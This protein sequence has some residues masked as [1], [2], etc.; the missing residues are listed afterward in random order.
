MKSK[1][2]N[3]LVIFFFVFLLFSCSL[4]NQS[5]IV[6]ID[7]NYVNNDY[8]IFTYAYDFQIYGLDNNKCCLKASTVSSL[9]SVIDNK[10][11]AIFFISSPSCISCKTIISLLN[12][13]CFDK[14]LTIYDIDL[15]SSIYPVFET[16]DFDI[17]INVLKNGV[18]NNENEFVIPIII[19][20]ND[21]IIEEYLL[22]Y[23]YHQSDLSNDQ[24][25]SKI[26]QILSKSHI[27]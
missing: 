20:I 11:T 6:N 9:K 16:D 17:L 8:E 27:Y 21:G 5:E 2:Y 7:S 19:I 12:D 4:D 18:I 15:Y 3:K 22:G 25:Y 23:D 1:V 10:Q 14:N 13:I 26:E 24:L